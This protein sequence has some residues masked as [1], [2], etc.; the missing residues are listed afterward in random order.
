[1]RAQEFVTDFEGINIAVEEE[2]DDLMLRARAGGREMGHAYF[3]KDGR[4]LLPQDLE[5]DPRYQGQGIARV[6]YNYAKSLGYE[7]RRS[8]QQTDAGKAFWQRH[9]PGQNVWEAEAKTATAKQVLAYI[10]QT[11]HEPMTAKLTAAVKKHPQW[12]LRQVPLRNLN[13]PDQDYEDPEQEPESDPYGRVMAVDPDHA[14]EYSTQIIDQRPIVIDDQGYIIDGNHRAWAAAELL[15]RDSIQ[16]WVPT[17]QLTELNYPDELNVSDA[18]QQYFVKRGYQVAGEG[19][20][21]IAFESPR[22]TVVKVLG[23]GEQEREEVV[24][25]YVKFFVE[26][27]NNPYYPRIYNTG[28]FTVGNETYFVYE[29]EYL[30]Y[31]SNE[32]EVLE[33]IEDLMSAL[34]RGKQ[35]LQAFYQNRNRPQSISP[36][37]LAGLVKATYDLEK[38]IGGQAP[39]D[40]SMI[41]NIRRRANGHLVIM[42]PYSL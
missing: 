15:N 31:V 42:D 12:E 34:P 10:N 5:I 18:L 27:Q 4:T 8:N 22:G 36:E 28:N 2:A 40:L 11:H 9:K 23:I 21:Q 20:D 29:Q 32:E 33:Y 3:V 35:A 38:N 1:M 24:K 17:E 14:N 41:E 6:L 26:N 37:E 16:A 19:R 39:L 7:I 25:R 30:N 13:I